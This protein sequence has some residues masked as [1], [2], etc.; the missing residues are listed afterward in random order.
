MLLVWISLFTP[1]K[2]WTEPQML[3]YKDDCGIR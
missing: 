2:G 3:F 1:I